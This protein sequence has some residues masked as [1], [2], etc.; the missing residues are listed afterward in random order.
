MSGVV[1]DLVDLMNST[2]L[3]PRLAVRAEDAEGVGAWACSMLGVESWLLFVLRLGACVSRWG[4][5][6]EA[7][8]ATANITAG[9]STV[10]RYVAACGAS[11]AFLKML[12]S[13][14]EE[15]A[16][17]VLGTSRLVLQLS[18]VKGTFG[19]VTPSSTT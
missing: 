3:D 9:S 2:R 1:P 8:W 19:G 10:T 4:G 18:L 15:L 16:E 11:G 14:S 7:G 5:Q 12:C 13:D 17:Q 6:L